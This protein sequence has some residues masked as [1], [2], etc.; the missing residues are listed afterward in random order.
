MGHCH[1]S[2]INR[3]SLSRFGCLCLHFAAL[4][5]TLVSCAPTT[6]TATTEVAPR[7]WRGLTPGHSTA[8]ELEAVLGLPD[9]T[10]TYPDFVMYLYYP[11]EGRPAFYNVALRADRVEM[12]SVVY[13]P[14]TEGPASEQAQPLQDEPDAVLWEVYLGREDRVL[15]YADSGYAVGIDLGHVTVE[16]FFVPMSL[17][18]YLASW[19]QFHPRMGLPDNRFAQILGLLDRLNLEP[20]RSTREEVDAALRG[21]PLVERGLQPGCVV[22]EYP[23]TVDEFGLDFAELW[24]EVDIIYEDDILT[25]IQYHHHPGYVPAYPQ[26]LQADPLDL[27]AIDLIRDHGEPEAVYVYRTDRLP[28][29]SA[30]LAYPSQ[31]VEYQLGDPIFEPGQLDPQQRVYEALWFGRTPPV[32]YEAMQSCLWRLTDHFVYLD[33]GRRLNWEDIRPY[34]LP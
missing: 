29:G 20:G 22:E 9:R 15:V 4:L 30:V 13:P 8:D 14:G 34:V 1:P 6:P 33:A 24:T 19:G 17:S 5:V 18:A 25:G 26:G 16:Q 12:I 23:I 28:Y 10:A 31:G 32:D 7:S 2:H 11:L 21:L 27:M 3:V